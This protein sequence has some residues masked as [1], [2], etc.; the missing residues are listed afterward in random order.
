LDED[1][2]CQPKLYAPLRVERIEKG[3]EGGFNVI[4]KWLAEEP[5]T[6]KGKLR[7]LMKN[8]PAEP[9]DEEGTTL[10]LH[11]PNPPVLCTGFEGSVAAAAGH[12]FEF[13][14]SGNKEHKGCLDGAPLLTENDESTIVQGVFLVGPTVSHGSLS[15]CFV[16]KFRQR[17]GIVA[18]AIC[19]GLGIDTRAAVDECRKA[20]MYLE[21]F[22]CCGDSC[23]DVC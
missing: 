7:G 18:N 5:K 16:Y 22:G 1:F 3:P 21:D 10:V 6:K 15:F 4:A 19:E 11:T 23:G 13:A 2:P 12:L 8:D 17:F 20:N 9:R 14:E